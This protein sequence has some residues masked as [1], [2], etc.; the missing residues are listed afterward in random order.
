MLPQVAALNWGQEPSNKKSSDRLRLIQWWSVWKVCVRETALVGSGNQEVPSAAMG[1]SFHQLNSLVQRWLRGLVLHFDLTANSARQPNL[2]R[3]SISYLPG[4]LSVRPAT[5]NG[6]LFENCP[7][8]E[9]SSSLQAPSPS[10]LRDNGGLSPLAVVMY[11]G[12]SAE[13]VVGH[14]E[15]R[16]CEGGIEEEH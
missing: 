2:D 10:S 16:S 13:V 15:A 8:N 1:L 12:S 6:F 4:K 9:T 5:L 14:M 3:D 11:R 7:W